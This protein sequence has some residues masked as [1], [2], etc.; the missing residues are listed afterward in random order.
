MAPT[1]DAVS[2]PTSRATPSLTASGHSVTLRTTST[3]FFRNGAS[4]WIPRSDARHLSDELRIA[5]RRHQ[6]HAFMRH[7][8]P[9]E[10]IT[11][12]NSTRQALQI[13]SFSGQTGSHVLRLSPNSGRP[14]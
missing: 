7:P 11:T 2:A 1:M 12:T 13:R 5:Q 4:S 14:H 10:D 9:L 3:G 6:P 8:Q